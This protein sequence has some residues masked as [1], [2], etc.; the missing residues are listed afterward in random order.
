MS[1][2][3]SIR[4]PRVAF[5]INILG[6]YVNALIAIHIIHHPWNRTY[7]RTA[8]SL[9]EQYFWTL[10]RFRCCLWSLIECML[11]CQRQSRC[12]AV[13]NNNT[14]IQNI[15]IRHQILYQRFSYHNRQEC[16]FSMYI[17]VF[18]GRKKYNSLRL[19]DAYMCHQPRPPLVQIMACRLFGANP[20]SEPILE[21]C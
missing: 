16:D 10:S 15:I 3:T 19:S 13:G 18:V 5:Y 21:Y 17:V 9:S 2:N 14:D 4:L 7:S 1:V 8:F 6:L 12:M 20:L 11:T